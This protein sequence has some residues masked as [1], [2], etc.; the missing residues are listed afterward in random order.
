MSMS[1]LL[2]NKLVNRQ[3]YFVIPLEKLMKSEGESSKFLYFGMTDY[4]AK[5]ECR[6]ATDLEMLEA[7]LTGELK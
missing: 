6:P 3:W 4:W 7:K 5:A 2:N 1:K